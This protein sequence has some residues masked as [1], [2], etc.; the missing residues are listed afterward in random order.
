MLKK[1]NY[2]KLLRRSI[3]VKKKQSPKQID[4][5]KQIKKLCQAKKQIN[6]YCDSKQQIMKTYIYIQSRIKKWFESGKKNTKNQ[7]CKIVEHTD[8][9]IHENLFEQECVC[10][11]QSKYTI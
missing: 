8:Q 2:F 4:P 5:K 3:K 1:K 6:K 7:N 11:N 10:L 9:H